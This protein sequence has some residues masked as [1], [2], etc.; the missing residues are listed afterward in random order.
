MEGLQFII[1]YYRGASRAKQKQ[2]NKGAIR[3]SR[4][5]PQSRT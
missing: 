3:C 4:N 2:A 1:E 5:S